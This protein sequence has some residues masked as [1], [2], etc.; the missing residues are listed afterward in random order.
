MNSA[1]LIT[2]SEKAGRGKGKN[3]GKYI[4][5]WMYGGILILYYAACG[6]LDRLVFLFDSRFEMQ[7]LVSVLSLFVATCALMDCEAS[8]SRKRELFCILVLLLCVCA[9][10]RS[11]MWTAI[12]ILILLPLLGIALGEAEAGRMKALLKCFFVE[13]LFL[14]NMP[15]F[16][17]LIGVNKNGWYFFG[18]GIAG[19]ILLAIF[20][21]LFQYCRGTVIS[22]DTQGKGDLKTLRR[23]IRGIL[24]GFGVFLT[25][26][27]LGGMKSQIVQT[28]NHLLQFLK[29]N[30]SLPIKASVDLLYH[31]R[32]SC[33]C[34]AENNIF[35]YLGG[36]TPFWLAMIVITLILAVMLR[37]YGSMGTWNDMGERKLL[38]ICGI[39]GMLILPVTI[40]TLPVCIGMLYAGGNKSKSSRIRQGR[41]RECG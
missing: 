17:T 34:A 22:G 5:I 38:L 41:K 13:S 27:L 39:T 31:V 23:I 35:A 19:E 28:K 26:L 36:K 7:A 21:L 30:E 6:L 3:M 16:E 33:N 1:V 37:K 9:N 15:L 29:T 11:G 8:E 20:G 32:D 18:S 14:C 2:G 40:K 12:L 4:R 24:G 10:K 25:G